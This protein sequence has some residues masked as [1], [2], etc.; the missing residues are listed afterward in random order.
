MPSFRTAAFEL[1][2]FQMPPFSTTAIN[3]NSNVVVVVAGFCINQLPAFPLSA[4][5]STLGNILHATMILF[6][7]F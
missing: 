5:R 2:E 4:L 3:E 7:F 1:I 6:Y